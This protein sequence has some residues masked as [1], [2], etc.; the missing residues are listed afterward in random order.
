M[1]A[2]A[3]AFTPAHVEQNGPDPCAEREGGIKRIPCSENGCE[4]FLNKVFGNRGFA[5]HL[6]GESQ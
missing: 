3:A 4:C 5:E 6:R 2:A 1:G